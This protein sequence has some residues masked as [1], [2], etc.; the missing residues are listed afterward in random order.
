MGDDGDDYSDG[1]LN[2]GEIPTFKIYDATSGG[3]YDAEP[4]EDIAW[5]N[6]GLYTLDYIS[7]FSELAYNFD[8]HYGANLISFYALLTHFYVLPTHF[9]VLEVDWRRLITHGTVRQ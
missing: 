9:Y 6:N 7:G 1:Y 3:I 2:S 8:L 5:A 4:S